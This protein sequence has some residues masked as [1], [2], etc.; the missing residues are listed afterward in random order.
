MLGVINSLSWRANASL[1]NGTGIRETARVLKISPT[2]VIENL[3]KSPQLQVVNEARLLE[4]E[5]TQTMVR[6]CQGEDVEAQLDEIWSFVRSKQDQRWVW[7]AIDPTPG[8]GLAY[9]LADH[10][11]AAFLELKT[12]LAPLGMTQSYTDGWGAYERHIEPV[13]HTV[14]KAQT[15]TIERKHLTLRTRIKR[16]ACK[17]ICFSK[18]AWLQDGVIA[19]FIE[20]LRG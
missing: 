15:Q 13:L 18:S 9:G 7:H 3:K 1:L 6:L 4:L 17:P 2:T 5:P 20:S 14:G 16:S 8:K 12:L 19:L 10:Q 11:D